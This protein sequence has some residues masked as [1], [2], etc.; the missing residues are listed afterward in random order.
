MASQAVYAPHTGT[1][2]NPDS[3]AKSEY[4]REAEKAAQTNAGSAAARNLLKKDWVEDVKLR[5]TWKKSAEEV[6]STL[7]A[8]VQPVL[9]LYS[10]SSG[11]TIRKPSSRIP[12]QAVRRFRIGSA[13]PVESALQDLS[14]PVRS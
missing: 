10:L 12:A 8:S 11:C 2:L 14:R 7:S 6:V 9:I 3:T 13:C 5:T 1:D 4:V